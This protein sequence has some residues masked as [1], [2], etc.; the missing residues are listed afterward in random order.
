MKAL[1]KK[2]LIFSFYE[3]PRLHV[4]L[5]AFFKHLQVNVSVPL[6]LLARHSCENIQSN[7]YEAPPPYSRRYSQFPVE[8]FDLKKPTQKEPLALDQETTLCLFIMPLFA[9]SRLSILSL[10]VPLLFGWQWATPGLQRYIEVPQI[11]VKRG[12]Q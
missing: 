10:T 8:I 7:I 12:D 9:G 5:S 1:K 3:V 6:V 4:L 2:I 11:S